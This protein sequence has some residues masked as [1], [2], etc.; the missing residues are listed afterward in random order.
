MFD[1]FEYGV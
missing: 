1:N